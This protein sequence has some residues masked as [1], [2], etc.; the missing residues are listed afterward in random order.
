MRKLGRKPLTHAA[1]R[2]SITRVRYA[3]RVMI[4]F[5]APIVP[6]LVVAVASCVRKLIVVCNSS[7][8]LV[9]CEGCIAQF[10]FFNNLNPFAV[11][12]SVI[13]YI[14]TRPTLGWRGTTSMTTGRLRCDLVLGRGSKSRKRDGKEQHGEEQK[15]DQF[16][17]CF[18]H[19]IYLLFYTRIC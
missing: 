13:V 12:S 5:R 10:A 8:K 7:P 4:T 17:C 16:S 9:A 2:C 6:C 15:T 14:D 1:V 11:G 3:Y 18:F 19:C